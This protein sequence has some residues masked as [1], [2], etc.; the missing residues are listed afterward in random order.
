MPHNV[1]FSWIFLLLLSSLVLTAECAKP[2]KILGLFPHPAKSHFNFFHPILRGLVDA[3]HSVDVVS[4]FPDKRA[5]ANYTNYNLASAA[6]INIIDLN[7][8]EN[9]NQFSHFND[10]MALYA[11]G[12]EACNNTLSSKALESI[13]AHPPDYYD[14]ILMEHFN[15]DCMMG[16]AHKLQAP[17]VAMSST[18]LLPWHYERM[19]VPIIPSFLPDLFLGHSQQMN[20]GERLLNW[21]TTHSLNWLYKLFSVPAADQLLRQKFGPG[22]PSTGELVKN[23][24]LFLINQHYSLSGPKPL[25]PSVIEVGGVHIQPPGPLPAQL[26]R[27]LENA[28]HGVVLMSWGSMVRATTMAPAKRDAILRAMSRFK[29]HFVWKWE[30]DTLPNKPDNVHIMKWIPQRDILAHPNVKAMI[31]HGGLLGTTEAIHCG[32]P[33]LG[34]P[35]FGDQFQNVAALVQR[36]AA[37]RLDYTAITEDALVKALTKVLDKS[38]K[39][40][41]QAIAHSYNERPQKPLETA[42][43]WVEY[44]AETGGAPLTQPSSV[45]MSRFIYYSLDVYLVV[46]GA[47]LLLLAIAREVK[48]VCCA[49]KEESS[50]TPSN[51]KR[52][53]K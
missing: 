31:S 19:G 48:R 40:N 6:Y 49:A 15:T 29:Q 10:F 42:L 5:P 14:V 1:P 30:N 27:L 7:V 24:S 2:L 46:L 8:V 21:V 28:K 53:Q 18:G 12:K 17:V 51:P 34:T 32:V 20:L 4:P 52:K 50:K 13:L 36:G 44:A 11:M 41:A 9:R 47:L 33:I 16:V 22:I 25:P 38:Y 26:K 45:H 35:M 37:V 43:W 39:N 23:T 3:G